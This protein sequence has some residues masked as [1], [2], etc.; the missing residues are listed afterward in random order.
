MTL[1]EKLY[2]VSDDIKAR[3][4]RPHV[5]KKTDRAFDSAIDSLIFKKEEAEANLEDLRM[6]IANGEVEAIQKIVKERRLI[7]EMEK[8]IVILGA[9]HA[10]QTEEVEKEPKKKEVS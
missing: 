8:Q 1:R 3:I 10:K 9:E 4:K 2:K 6:D 5:F 7:E